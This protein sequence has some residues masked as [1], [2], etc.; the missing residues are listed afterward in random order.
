MCN[1]WMFGYV[2]VWDSYYLRVST[3]PV[4]NF[5]TVTICDGIFTK[6]FDKPEKRVNISPT[7]TEACRL[8]LL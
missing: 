3:T 2:F 5:M 8:M 1:I 6:T 7:V 4:L